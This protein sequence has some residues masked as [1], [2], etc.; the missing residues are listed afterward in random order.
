MDFKAKWEKNTTG[1]KGSRV[2]E[3]IEKHLG[4]LE[5]HGSC[6]EVTKKK[7]VGQTG[8]GEAGIAEK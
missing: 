6:G 5:S 8:R 3:T 1:Q 4:H 7:K 2:V